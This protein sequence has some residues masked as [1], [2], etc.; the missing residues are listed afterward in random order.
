MTNAPRPWRARATLLR[1]LAVLLAL[2]GCAAGPGID[3]RHTSQNQDSRVLFIVIHYTVGDFDNAL[4]VLTRGNVS[5]HYLVDDRDFTVYRLVDE[6]RRAWHAGP[7]CW[8]SHCG[9]NASSVGIEIVNPGRRDGAFMP[10]PPQQIDRVVALVRDIAE[11]HQV[12]AERVLGH[13]EIAPLHKEDPGPLFPWRRLADEGLIAWPTDE[14]LALARAVVAHRFPDG[15]DIA[16]F[17]ERLTLHGMQVP[18][19]GLLDE[20]TRRALTMFQMRYRPATHDGTPDTETAAW[21]VA[22][23]GDGYR[24][25]AR[26]TPAERRQ[27]AGAGPSPGPAGTPGANGTPA[28]D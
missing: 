24:A 21:L 28:F 7:S 14:E 18:R 22:L 6:S 4:K 13:N 26:D 17:Q 16:W 12:R 20:G 2:A 23:T 27:R 8:K 19:T 9:L 25:R 10:F 5:A 11:R 15:P 1:P 3:T